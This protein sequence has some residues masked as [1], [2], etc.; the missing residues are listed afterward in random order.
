VSVNAIACAPKTVNTKL[1]ES[2]TWTEY[3]G[4]PGRAPSAGEAL[5]ADPV[6][7]WQR[8]TGRASAGAVALGD[9]VIA[10]QASDQHVHLVSRADG[11]RRWRARLSG[12][13]ASGPLLTPEHVY[14]ATGGRDGS[15]HALRIGSGRREWARRVGPVSGTLA[16]FGTRVFAST[17]RGLVVGLARESGDIE[18]RRSL[19]EAVRTGVTYVNGR[20][21]VATDDS[22]YLL[23]PADGLIER[24]V[25]APG[26]TLSPPAVVGDTLLMTS[27][28]G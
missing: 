22:L 23:S 12:P 18:W 21:F 26:P 3:L 1:I 28:Q 19:G 6:L 9:S 7:Q 8:G 2:R 25:G 14:A 4:S 16:V 20:L 13:G 17:E 24:V 10:I 27:P 11:E 15:V 5:P